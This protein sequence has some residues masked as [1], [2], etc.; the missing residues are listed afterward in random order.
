MFFVYIK[1]SA[2]LQ[3]VGAVLIIIGSLGIEKGMRW[4]DRIA[5]R[6]LTRI[7][8]IFLAEFTGPLTVPVAH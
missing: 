5:T 7:P 4:T 8:T 1:V 2:A 3:F 6:A